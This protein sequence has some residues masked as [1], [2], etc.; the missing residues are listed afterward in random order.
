MNKK[1][2][3]WERT[4]GRGGEGE[5]DGT[6]YNQNTLIYMYEDSMMKPTKIKGEGKG[7]RKR[8]RGEFDQITLQA[9]MKIPQ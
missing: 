1:G 5:I 8:N 7:I 4:S 9:Y 3:C 6:K 2:E